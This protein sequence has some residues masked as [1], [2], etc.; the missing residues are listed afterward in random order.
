MLINTT[1]NYSI[2][3]A[4]LIIFFYCTGQKRKIITCYE[5]I[6]TGD[7]M[8]IKKLKDLR[9]DNDLSQ[10]EIAKKTKCKSLYIC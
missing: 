8:Y 3:K 1:Y 7:I 9:E 10:D 2:Q 5:K 4:K 6:I